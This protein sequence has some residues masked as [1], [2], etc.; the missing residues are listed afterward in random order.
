MRHLD[1]VAREEPSAMA[2]VWNERAEAL[3]SSI[4]YLDGLAE[5]YGRLYRQNPR[6]PCD[7]NTLV[8]EQAGS[9]N[10]NAEITVD[11]RLGKDLP[12]VLADPIAVRRIL[13]N[14]V[15]NAIESFETDSG[16]VVLETGFRPAEDLVTLSVFDNGP[17]IPEADQSRI[18]GDF[19]TTKDHGTGLGLSIVRRLVADCDGAIQVRSRPGEGTRFEITFPAAGVSRSGASPEQGPD[20]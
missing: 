4:D 6:R 8:R 12:A 9:Q 16:R 1:Q 7:L 18:F 11:V 2:G 19:F 10:G 5:N 14:L 20:R 15:T 13:D 3:K 17:G